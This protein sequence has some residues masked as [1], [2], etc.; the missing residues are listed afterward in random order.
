MSGS[1]SYLLR[2]ISLENLQDERDTMILDF[3]VLD[4]IFVS[5]QSGGL[6][7]FDILRHPALP[8]TGSAVARLLPGSH[9]NGFM[10]RD[11]TITIPSL[12]DVGIVR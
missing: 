11:Q 3:A 2:G 7:T 12:C 8:L 5:E 10:F 1:I 4:L 9:D 6:V